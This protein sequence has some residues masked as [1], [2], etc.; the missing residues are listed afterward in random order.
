MI[1]GTDRTTA[2]SQQDPPDHDRARRSVHALLRASPLTGRN[3]SQEPLCR[4]IVN[5]LLD[6]A[7]AKT[8][9]DVVDEFA[10]PLPV[11]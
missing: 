9:I 3:P 7:T 10:Y 8:R 6:T 4:Q 1:E 5:D 11:R 2:S